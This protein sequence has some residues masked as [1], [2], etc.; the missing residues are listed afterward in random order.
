MSSES[1][2]GRGGG[3]RLLQVRVLG[4]GAPPK[5][6][7]DCRVGVGWRVAP[8]LGPGG[9]DWAAGLLSRLGGQG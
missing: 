7:L 9:A 5:G 4:R 2:L 8:L 3:G 1:W 6:A